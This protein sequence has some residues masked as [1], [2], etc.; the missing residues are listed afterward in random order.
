M[1]YSVKH[2]EYQLVAYSTVPCF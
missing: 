1:V 2:R